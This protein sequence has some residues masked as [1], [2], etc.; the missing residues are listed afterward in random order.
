M[1]LFRRNV[2]LWQQL[3]TFSYSSDAKLAKLGETWSTGKERKSI[4]CP[5]CFYSR[6]KIHWHKLYQQNLPEYSDYESEDEMLF[7]TPPDYSGIWLEN[8]KELE[9]DNFSNI[10]REVEFVKLILAKSPLLMKVRIVLN[11]DASEN[12]DL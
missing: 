2:F 10:E 1:F 6:A 12:E 8:L 11:N 3:L 4:F 5:M 7:F 9:I